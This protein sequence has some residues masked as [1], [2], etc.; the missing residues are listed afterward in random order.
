MGELEEISDTKFL[1]RKGESF[2]SILDH[3][4]NL[5]FSVVILESIMYQIEKL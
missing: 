3:N 5:A 1:K 2:K 4:H